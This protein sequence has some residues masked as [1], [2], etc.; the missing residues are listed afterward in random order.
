MNFF[1]FLWGGGGVLYNFLA[2]LS[3]KRISTCRQLYSHSGHG[4]RLYQA[5]GGFKVS[6]VLA[7]ARAPHDD[8]S[9]Y[10][11]KHLNYKHERQTRNQ[12]KIDTHTHTL[13]CMQNAPRGTLDGPR[14][15]HCCVIASLSKTTTTTTTTTCQGWRIF[16][17]FFFSLFCFYDGKKKKNPPPKKN[18]ASSL[19]V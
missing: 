4:A 16:F 18:T 12:K 14:A 11:H 7:R 10:T 17:S 1:D 6:R 2:A 8:R 19:V 9:S 13:K 3:S 15:S 5:I